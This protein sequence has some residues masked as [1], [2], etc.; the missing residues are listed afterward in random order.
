MPGYKILSSK[1]FS[2]S[3]LYSDENPDTK[4]RYE[5][6]DG[7][8]VLYLTGKYSYADIPAT[9]LF[10]GIHYTM[11]MWVKIHASQSDPGG[12]PVIFSDVRSSAVTTFRLFYFQLNPYDGLPDEYLR[13]RVFGNGYFINFD[14][15]R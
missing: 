13:I 15:P 3:S 9:K 1:S 5:I 7:Q 4:A 11:L 6:M 14:T 12:K 10:N 8:T 2:H